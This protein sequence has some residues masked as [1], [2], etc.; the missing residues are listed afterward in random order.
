MQEL[1]GCYFDLT[2]D[3]ARAHRLVKVAEVDWG[4]M[5]C[6]TGTSSRIWVN[7]VG[8]FGISS[9]AY[10]WSRLMSGVGRAVYYAL[11]KSELFLLV[12]VD[13]LLWMVREAKGLELIVMSIFYLE[14]LGFLLRGRSSRVA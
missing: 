13:D 3:V 8:S 7:R 12:Y 2:G 10:H 11:G 5:A 14:V 4:L 1:P 9:A 6:K